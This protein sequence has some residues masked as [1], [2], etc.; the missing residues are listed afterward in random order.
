MGMSL[1]ALGLIFFVQPSAAGLVLGLIL[2]YVAFFAVGM[3]PGV[4]VVLAE[5][6]PTRIRARAMS[7]ATVTLWAACLLVSL[8]F[9]TLVKAI[10]ASG[11][12]WTYA[13]MSLFTFWFVWRMLP[14]TTGKSLEDI[15]RSWH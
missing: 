10:G 6:F 7:V 11:A 1:A 15:E 12:F 3:G 14:E 5:L 4:W 9:L 13:V 2:C 8:T